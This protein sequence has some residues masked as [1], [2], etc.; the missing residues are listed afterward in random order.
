MSA[1]P[2]LRQATRANLSIKVTATAQSILVLRQCSN[3]LGKHSD[4]LKIVQRS[5]ILK[6]RYKPDLLAQYRM[7]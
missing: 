5:N 6:V 3:G 4:V 7:I 2:L 1:T